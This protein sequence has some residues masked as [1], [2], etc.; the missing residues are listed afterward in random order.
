MNIYERRLQ[1]AWDEYQTALMN[2]MNFG[3]WVSE[4]E[5]TFL[6]IA[7]DEAEAAFEAVKAEANASA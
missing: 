3:A 5:A 2:W 1:I 6:A 4:E 7:K